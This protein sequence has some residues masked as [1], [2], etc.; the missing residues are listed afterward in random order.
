MNS[1]LL[2]ALKCK[3]LSR[4]PIW[5]MRQAGRYM[6]DYRALRN[7]HSFLEMVHTP[8]LAA[9]VT[10]LP[11]KQIG[12]DAAILFSDILVIVEALGMKLH[13]DDGAGPRIESPL[14]EAKDIDQLPEPCIE[15]SLDYVGQAIKGLLPQLKVPLIGFCGAPFT[16]ASYMIEG[17]S[18][19]DLRK[20]KQW[21]LSDP[22][23]FHRLLHHIAKHTIQYLEMQ[24]KAG[25]HA[26][27]IFDS[28][29]N[30]LGHTQFRE[31]SLAY[32]KMIVDSLRAKDIPIILF[33]KGSS[34]FA[35]QLAEI[36]PAAISVDWNSNLITLQHQIPSGI[37][38]QGNLD[39]DILYAPK[40]VIKKE[41]L[42][43]LNGMKG[44]P[45][46]I[47][48]LGHGILPD[49]PFENVRTLIET[50]KCHDHTM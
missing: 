18:S 42:T 46:Y 21:M 50:V 23:S 30:F 38:L 19:R 1:L 41:A 3:N 22:K 43:L 45:G 37:A 36:R 40:E 20:T 11:V 44:N 8:E 6:P 34:V 27:Q 24:V 13:F 15:T 29:A 28:W 2:D 4:P 12:V 25:V 33:C 26:V 35:P 31:F 9:E 16:I 39:P 47:F 14:N 32:L 7:K 48:N 10:L 49:I 5:L 17:K